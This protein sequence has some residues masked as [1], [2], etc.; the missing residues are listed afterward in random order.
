MNWKVLIL[1]PGYQPLEVVAWTKALE[2]LLTG[3]AEVVHEYDDIPIRSEKLSFNL[4]SV[5][6][7]LKSFTKRKHVKFSRSNIFFRDKYCCQYCGKK[8]ETE[9]LTF[10]HVT[11]KC[12][13]T[14]NS[15]KSWENIATC[16]IDCNRKKGGRTP[17]QAGMRLLKTPAKPAW[18]PA[19]TI[20]IKSTDPE[21]WKSFCYWNIDLEPI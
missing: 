10:D 16:C 6:R 3:K 11:P 20:K 12:M 17:Q 4:P 15:H 8:K 21:A 5:V 19:M 13:R 9:E 18:S 2:L 14:E 1:D 7:L